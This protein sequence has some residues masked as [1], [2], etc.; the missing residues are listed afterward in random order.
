MFF[1]II[2]PYVNF[3]LSF[4]SLSKVLN[5]IYYK[6]TTFSKRFTNGTTKITTK[7]VNMFLYRAWD[8][9]VESEDCPWISKFIND[10][11]KLY[12]ELESKH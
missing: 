7:N 1:N 6:H 12:S 11:F 8:M 3:H 2:K 5:R 4:A 9:L 10:N